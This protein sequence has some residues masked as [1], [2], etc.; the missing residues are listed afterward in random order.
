LFVALG[1]AALVITVRSV[2]KRNERELHRRVVAR[3]RE[4]I[5]KDLNEGLAKK[6]PPVSPAP[7]AW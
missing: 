1:I 3:A 7:S 4:E 6:P 5:R 2:K